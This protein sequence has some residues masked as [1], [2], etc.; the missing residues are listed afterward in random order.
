MHGSGDALAVQEELE[1]DKPRLERE[2]QQYAQQAAQARADRCLGTRFLGQHHQLGLL[3]LHVAQ[4]ALLTALHEHMQPL[5]WTR[6]AEV[7]WS[8]ALRVPRL[9]AGRRPRQ[10]PLRPGGA[11]P[12]RGMTCTAST[13]CTRRCQRLTD[14]R[15][16]QTWQVLAASAHADAGAVRC[17]AGQVR[18]VL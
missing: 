1:A 17:P 11:V 16:T 6:G 3:L 4:G 13:R 18:Q 2:Q 7:A 12:S 9:A 5:V 15:V 10:L 14:M 8:T